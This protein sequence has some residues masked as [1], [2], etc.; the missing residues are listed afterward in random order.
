M[1]MKDEKNLR[2]V[3]RYWRKRRGKS[4]EQLARE[5]EVSTATIVKIE[6][7]HTIPRADVLQRLTQTLNI[8][9][10]QLIVDES[11]VPAA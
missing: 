1:P 5:A 3:L 4:I 8:T 2:V 9:I 11:E 6:K 7:G 10:D